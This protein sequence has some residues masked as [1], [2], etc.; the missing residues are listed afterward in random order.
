MSGHVVILSNARRYT[1]KTSSTQLINDLLLEGCKK[2]GQLN[3]Q[4]YTLKYGSSVL[5]LSLPIRL[6]RLPAGAKLMLIRREYGKSDIKVALQIID[7][8]K[9]LTLSFPS[10]TTLWDIL[11]QFE[12]VED[13]PINITRRSFEMASDNRLDHYY[14]TPVVRIINKEFNGPNILKNITLSS[15][16]ITKGNVLIQVKFEKTQIYF[17]QMIALLPKKEEK[18]YEENKKMPEKL[19]TSEKQEE[20]TCNKLLEAQPQPSRNILFEQIDNQLISDR[21]ILVLSVPTSSNLYSSEVNTNEE[22]YE[23]TQETAMFYQNIL[24]A[25]AKGYCN[26]KINTQQKTEQENNLR[27]YEVKFKLP[28][29]MQVIGTFYGNENVQ[30]LYD[31]IKHIMHYSEEPFCLYITPPPKYLLNM[32]VTLASDP[33]FSTKTTIIFKWEKNAQSY[34]KTHS[35]LK[36]IYLNLKTD[37]PTNIECQEDKQDKREDTLTVLTSQSSSSLNKSSSKKIP[38]WLK[39]S[40]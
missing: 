19:P 22:D 1:I 17:D 6:A 8:A 15:Q 37:M 25:K 4:E 40:K 21:K 2:A 13:P 20:I 34:V 29:G 32:E 10:Q 31:F 11:C 5:D 33:N 3:P 24:S 7:L 36:D 26:Q 18:I 9:R 27:K 23:I 16:G 28:D 39:L 35:I 30:A 14:E 38:K 12:E